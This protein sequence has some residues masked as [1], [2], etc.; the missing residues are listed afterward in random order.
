MART[1]LFR[2][3]ENDSHVWYQPEREKA[4]DL[5]VHVAHTDHFLTGPT[6]YLHSYLTEHVDDQ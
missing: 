3:H 4:L 6:F 2:S 5:N 1:W